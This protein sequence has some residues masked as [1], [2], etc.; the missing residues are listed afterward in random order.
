MYA[1]L[2]IRAQLTV[3]TGLHIG[4][5]SAFSAIGAVDSPVIA[6][7]L[8]NQPIIPGSSL[9]GKLRSLLVRATTN[10]GLKLGSID[11]DPA[12]VQRLFGCAKPVMPARLQFADAFMNQD[13]PLPVSPREVKSENTID[14]G[15]CVANPRQ[16]ERV[17]PGV[18]FDVNIAYTCCEADE[19]ME[20]MEQLARS[21][22]LLQLDYLG[23]HGS[24]GY[25]RVRLD[26]IRLENPL[27]ESLPFDINDGQALL[28]E[29]EAY[30]LLSV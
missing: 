8:D 23:G 1:K 18:V 15:T 30:G 27:Q 22:K 13:K 5:S 9:K 16:I 28:K 2:L 26:N 6:N 25:G 11:Q 17:I 3:V 19:F 20:D 12:V 29:V 10:S 7:P 21:L 24:R 4:G 14:R